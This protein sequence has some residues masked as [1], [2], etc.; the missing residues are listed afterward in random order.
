MESHNRL[1]RTKIKFA[2]T[3]MIHRYR[4]NEGL[5]KIPK[6]EYNGDYG[7]ILRWKDGTSISS[8][9]EGKIGKPEI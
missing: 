4:I 3:T 9:E 1:L 8:N 7:W 2:K 5:K 6:A